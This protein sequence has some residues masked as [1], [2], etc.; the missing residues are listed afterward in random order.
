MRSE[1]NANWN[2]GGDVP[3]LPG[4]HDFFSFKLKSL[5]SRA[6]LIPVVRGNCL[7]SPQ[8]IFSLFCDRA[9]CQVME[10]KE[11]CTDFP[12]FSQGRPRPSPT[13]LSR[14]IYGGFLA[15]PFA[16]SPAFVRHATRPA[17]EAEAVILRLAFILSELLGKG[18]ANE[19]ETW[20]ESQFHTQEC[21]YFLI[22]GNFGQK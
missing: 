5:F 19:L 14:K 2:E 13:H 1:R 16:S 21:V 11:C 17:A 12:L 22:N 15:S 7:L 3:C 18:G 10:K 6:F 9:S 4:K 20:L 8:R